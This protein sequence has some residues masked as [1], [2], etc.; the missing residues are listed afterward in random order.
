MLENKVY[1]EISA[2]R[3]LALVLLDIIA[4]KY[5]ICLTLA[6]KVTN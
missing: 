4:V 6:G 1:E 3:I 5:L 2:K